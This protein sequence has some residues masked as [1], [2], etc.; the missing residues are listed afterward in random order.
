M[1]LLL[2]VLSVDHFMIVLKEFKSMLTLEKSRLRLEQIK[3]NE[4]NRNLKEW[5]HSKRINP[6]QWPEQEHAE[7]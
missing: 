1:L 2:Q 3:Q 7:Q 6:Y 4:D 5:R